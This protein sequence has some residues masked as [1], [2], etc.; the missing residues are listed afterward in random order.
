MLG[1]QSVGIEGHTTIILRPRM[2]SG[3]EIAVGYTP[4]QT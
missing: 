2:D 4:G 1:V 3:G